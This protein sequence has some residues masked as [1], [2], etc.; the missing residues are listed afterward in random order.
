[1]FF[2][3]DAKTKLPNGERVECEVAH[4]GKWHEV[5]VAL[6]TQKALHALR[7]DPCDQAGVVRIKGLML[8]TDGKVL[9]AWP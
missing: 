5:S 7:L 2:T 8:K 1:M 4:D 9:K 6:K 3:T